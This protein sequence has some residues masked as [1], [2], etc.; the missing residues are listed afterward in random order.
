MAQLHDFL[1]IMIGVVLATLVIGSLAYLLFKGERIKGYTEGYFDGW[2]DG[3]KSKQEKFCKC[4]SALI[5]G[6]SCQRTDC[7]QNL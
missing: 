5:G 4:G 1:L 2:E 3:R 7:N 6:Y